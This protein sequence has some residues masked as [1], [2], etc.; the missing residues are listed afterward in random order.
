MISHIIWLTA[1][2][3]V[4]IF[5][6]HFHFIIESKK[7]NNPPNSPFLLFLGF[8]WLSTRIFMN[9]EEESE[10]ESDRSVYQGQRVLFSVNRFQ[11]YYNTI[12]L[13]Y[14]YSAHTSC[15]GGHLII[16]LLHQI[17]D[18]DQ[19]FSS[20]RSCISTFLRRF[21]LFSSAHIRHWLI[22]STIC[23]CRWIRTMGFPLLL[24]YN[25]AIRMAGF[26]YKFKYTI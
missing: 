20:H 14:F 16:F 1:V 13:V 22:N 17:Y 21:N 10:R 24:E 12:H 15:F 23:N 19:I 7:N 11:L 5:P 26:L 4:L 25:Y 6:I 2:N 3:C 8:K 18:D 9:E